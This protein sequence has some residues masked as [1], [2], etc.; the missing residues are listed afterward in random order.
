MIEAPP[1]PLNARERINGFVR[2]CLVCR[3]PHTGAVAATMWHAVRP[4]CGMGEYI[5]AARDRGHEPLAIVTW[6]ADLNW[7][8]RR[9]RLTFP[10]MPTK[11]YR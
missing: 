3:N 7:T 9:E 5:R 1:Y 8:L 10:K 4:N 11:V 6:K 2:K